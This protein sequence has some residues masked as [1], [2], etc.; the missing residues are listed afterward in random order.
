MRSCL[1]GLGVVL[2][3]LLL[4]LVFRCLILYLLLLHSVTQV[5]IL[6]GDMQ[7]YTR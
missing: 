7:S 3:P 6:I 1:A 5:V 4:L 2:I